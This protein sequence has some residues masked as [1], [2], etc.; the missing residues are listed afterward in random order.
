MSREN[1]FDLARTNGPKLKQLGESLIGSM[2][3]P[4]ALR[5]R[6]FVAVVERVSRIGIN[7]RPSVLQ[8]VVNGQPYQNTHSWALELS[9]LSGRSETEILVERL[10]TFYEARVRFEGLFAASDSFIYGTL[11]VGGVGASKYGQFCAILRTDAV[12]E[13]QLAYLRRD[14][15]LYADPSVVR[16]ASDLASPDA[17]VWL[18]LLKHTDALL[19]SAESAWH[20][21]VCNS[22]DYVEAIFIADI[23]AE[24][25]EE[26]R[27][28]TAV[29]S[30]LSE[31][32]FADFTR[33]LTE[34]ERSMAQDFISILRAARKGLF[35]LK[36]V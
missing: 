13:M 18:I 6:K 3:A 14:S 31:L 22:S 1:I 8:E 29:F 33:K 24:S 25:L 30:E 4:D 5:C 17:R 15:L 19:R 27:V 7:L 21:L 11:N 32:A 35:R 23:R 10:G 26:V 9:R 20:A 36:E 16:F 28:E 34:G 12:E 2:P